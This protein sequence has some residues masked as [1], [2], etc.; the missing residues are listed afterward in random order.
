VKTNGLV[1]CAALALS[2]ALATANFAEDAVDSI[3]ESVSTSFSESL[4]A[5][6]TADA[7]S[8]SLLD[9]ANCNCCCRG[10]RFWF[11]GAEATMLQANVRSGGLLTASFSDTTA[12]GVSTIAFRDGDGI[13]KLGV[14]PRLWIGRQLT[15]NWGIV[16]RYWDLTVAEKQFPQQNP[17]IPSTGTNFA[18]FE[19]RNTARLYAADL[20]L[21][22]SFYTLGWKI[23][24]LGGVRRAH[25]DCTSD[26]LAF[27]VFTTGNFINLTLQNGFSFDGVGGTGGLLGRRQIGN[28]PL[29]FLIGGRFSYLSGHTDS[30]ARADGAVASSPSAPLVG[31]GTVS[32]NESPATATIGEFQTGLQL[33]Y[34][35]A[36][37]PASAFLRTSFEYQ[38][39]II[40]GKPTGGVGFGGTIGEITTNSFASGG[41]GRANLAGVSIATGINW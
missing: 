6:D 23:D 32:R 3:S 39:W 15:Q 20:E 21:M 22:R 36:V 12:P 29:Q 37:I 38:N 41:L 10:S 1:R 26:F 16:A 35:L 17:A 25:I 34:P 11:A 4:T 40:H 5:S 31:A 9:E 7:S 30:F 28:L 13:N 24:A 2:V 14:A 19:E 33:D 18:T 8:G 27:G